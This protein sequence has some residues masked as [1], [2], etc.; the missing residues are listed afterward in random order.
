MRDLRSVEGTGRRSCSFAPCAARGLLMRCGGEFSQFFDPDEFGLCVACEKSDDLVREGA[1]V[2]A[3]FECVE[4]G[5]ALFEVGLALVEDGLAI[6]RCEDF[7]EAYA[8]AELLEGFGVGGR[9]ILEAGDQGLAALHGEGIDLARS[10]AVAF[11]RFYG[12]PFLG[13]EATKQWIDEIVVHVVGA[14]EL[15]SGFFE[16]VTVLGAFEEEG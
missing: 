11:C 7:E 16:G 14:E 15:G 6:V 12:D 8:D 3:P 4:A 9:E 5:G 1:H 2:F 13:N 10:A